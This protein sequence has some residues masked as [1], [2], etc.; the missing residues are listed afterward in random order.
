MSIALNAEGTIV[1]G[2]K[3]YPEPR[4]AHG[5]ARGA[6]SLANF[7]WKRI[8]K[9]KIY[10]EGAKAKVAIAG[11]SGI[12]F[13]KDCFTRDGETVARGDHIDL[14]K[15]GVTNERRYAG[16]MYKQRR[17]TFVRRLPLH[18]NPSPVFVFISSTPIHAYSV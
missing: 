7:L 10:T 12:V 9:P 15:L 6:E 5:H 3:T 1:I 16:Q 13:F 11:K 18:G 2:N 4:C 14:W 17:G 8:G